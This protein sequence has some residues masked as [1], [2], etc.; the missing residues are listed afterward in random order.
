MARANYP[1][2]ILLAYIVVQEQEVQELI[3]SDLGNNPAKS[4]FF[5]EWLLFVRKKI[6]QFEEYI[7]HANVVRLSKLLAHNIRES[8]ITQEIPNLPPA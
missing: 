1:T 5:V 8:W 2:H 3:I 6:E 4:N 7:D